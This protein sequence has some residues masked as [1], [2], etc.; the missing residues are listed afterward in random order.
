MRGL[1]A[2]QVAFYHCLGWPATAPGWGTDTAAAIAAA[3]YGPAAVYLFFVL[4]GLVLGLS[5]D[6]L[7]SSAHATVWFVPR[8]LV[9]LF[10][11]YLAATLLC[12]AL[13]SLA[14]AFSL[15][16]TPPQHL[17]PWNDGAG[18]LLR[19]LLML[20][21]AHNAPAWSVQIEV[22]AAAV[23]P[24]LW[25]ISRRSAVSGWL[26]LIAA[27]V[28]GQYLREPWLYLYMFQLGMMLPSL[29]Q[30]LGQLGRRA[31][32]A[33]WLAAAA[34][35]LCG[36]HLPVGRWRNVAIVSGAALMLLLVWQGRPAALAGWLQRPS[37][38]R[39]GSLSF[40]LYLLHHPCHAA[41]LALLPPVSGGA[42]ALVQVSVLAAVSIPLALGLAQLLWSTV[43]RP[44][45]RWAGRI[46]RP[47][48]VMLT[49]AVPASL[50]R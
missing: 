1:A 37:M 12:A 24:V 17:L 50:S 5:L 13:G 7:G 9:R 41:V 33:L 21:V 18:M 29:A 44:S 28:A 6:R 31:C 38:V 36:A 49:A 48:P 23:I 4:S 43:E 10:P 3:L 34:A 19:R 15:P 14:L 45:M 39:L 11:P 22:L 42:A 8:R 46:G 30:P 2:L 16:G 27:T 32:A 20:N 35:Y 25:W 26:L 47:T 40:S